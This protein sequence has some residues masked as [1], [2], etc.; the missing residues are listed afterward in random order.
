M[1]HD[2]AL[3]PQPGWD[4]RD[5]P[6]EEAPVVTY[7]LSPE[8]IAARYGPPRPRP[9][10]TGMA[11]VAYDPRLYK[12]MKPMTIDVLRRLAAEGLTAEEIAE[13]LGRTVAGVKYRAQQWG[14]RLLEDKPLVEERAEQPAEKWPVGPE[15]LKELFLDQGLKQVEI[16]QMYGVSVSAVNSALGRYGIRRRAVRFTSPSAGREERPAPTRVTAQ[17]NEDRTHLATVQVT[18]VMQAPCARQVLDSIAK[19]IETNPLMARVSVE[20]QIRAAGE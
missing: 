11:G 2:Y 20:I 12:P 15:R 3:P 19:L 10:A 8:E 13:R 5:E 6:P 14:V 16:A 18:G 7:R 4:L 9:V 1:M 17:V